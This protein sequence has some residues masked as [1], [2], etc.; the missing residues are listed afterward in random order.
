[1][2]MYT[3]RRCGNFTWDGTLR[4]LGNRYGCAGGERI[5]STMAAPSSSGLEV[6]L[7]TLQ[8]ADDTE[9][10]LNIL[11]VL[12]ELLSA[13][14][15]RRIHYMISKGGSEALLS[16]LV[17]TA[18][19][20]PPNY[21]LLLPILHL[22]AKVGH[23]DRRI[24]VKAEKAEAVLLI[25]GLL[26][27]NLKDVRRAA[28]CLWVIQVYCTSVS[29]ATLLGK[30]RGL[31]LVY[32][33]IPT[34]TT[35]HIRT[36]KAAIDALTALLRSKVNCR[37]AVSK[38]FITG[39]LKLFAD[40]HSSDPNCENLPIQ[41]AL[42]HCLHRATN[43]S[44]GRSSLVA[45]GGIALL[46]QTT[47]TCLYTRGMECLVEPTVQL[48]RKCCPKCP[49]PLASDQSVYSF[50]LPGKANSS[51]DS[52]PGI[53][54]DGFE[55]DSDSDVE[56][57]DAENRDYE[58]DLETDLEALRQ[59]P[60]PDRPLE[61][62]GQYVRLCPELHYDFQE[63]DS[64]SE[65][66]E[67]SDEDSLLNGDSDD[68]W[69]KSG[70]GSPRRKHKASSQSPLSCAL[71]NGHTSTRSR[72]EGHG[73]PEEDKHNM[74]AKDLH[75]QCLSSNE[76]GHRSMVDR[77]LEKFGS[78]IP[79]HDP[80]LYAA[81]AA[82]TR[83]IAGY[84]ILAFPDFWGH[85]PPS[86]RENMAVRRPN[87]Q[88]KKVLEDIQ[89]FLCPEDIINKVVF[90]LEDP[91][92]QCSSEHKDSLRF[93]SKFEC[94]NLRKAVHVRRYE[95][96]LILNADVNTSQY[97]QWFYFEVSGMVANVPY[98]FN[99]I[100]GE[101]TNSQFN[102][103]M[104]PVLYSVR[105]ALEGRPHWV[106]T[107]T[108]I[109]YY[110]NH[111][112]PSGQKGS[113][114]Y[115][116]TFTVTFRHDEDVCYLAYHYA[117]TYS[118]LQAHLQM[119]QRSVDP[120]KVFFRQQSL[121]NTLAGN[122]CPLV[123]IT[124]CPSSRS[125]KNL[126]Q[127]RNRP[128]VVL[129]ARVHPGESNASWVMKG[130]LEFLCS[131]DPVAQSLREAFIFKIIPMLNP[132]GVI[133][134]THRCSLT[135]EDL[136]RQWKKPDPSLSPTIYH[137]KGFLYYLNSIGRTPLVF[138]DYHGHSRKKNVF[139]Y[140]CSV[141]ETLWQSGSSVDTATLK[142]D[143]GY[144]TISKTL[145]RIAPAFSFNSCNYLVEKSRASTAR[146]VVWREIGVLRSY[147]MESTYNGCDQGIYQ[148]MQLGTRELAEMGSKFCQSLLTLRKSAMLY[149][150]KVISHMALLDDSLLD[151]KSHNCFV[152]DEPP[153][154][155]EIEYHSHV[156]L[157]PP[158]NDLDSEVNA[159]MSNTEDDDK[160][161]DGD[162]QKSLRRGNHSADLKS[163]LYPHL[164]RQ[165]SLESL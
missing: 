118:A 111:F 96:D 122:S 41:K 142:E 2:K 103:G 104:Q 121:C 90:D 64:E 51:W 38:G 158:C 56:N 69:L 157:D 141:K 75:S 21:T 154:V 156:T 23:R 55:D 101:K 50:P 53:Q 1:M 34:H 71:R 39:L 47:Q 58:D 4:E 30:N 15:D 87:L 46:F 16:A 8:D 138:C 128:C 61:Q 93:F 89:R 135:G 3:Y 19:S 78:C 116:L 110:R 123:T 120:R 60:E 32:R 153:C 76:E 9:S 106:R 72:G 26:R 48:M 42:L 94:G 125:W 105:E 36:I 99:I 62:L 13:G 40:W 33:L 68:S 150:S 129:T 145:D 164:C 134:G 165:D 148:G 86:G 59:R 12:D 5:R 143:P 52:M 63:L 124:A 114:F 84:S 67:S 112:Q 88:R 91:S 35:K 73:T 160:D 131:S 100:N 74:K 24:G 159:N 17:N 133:N 43:T 144:R 70:R 80:R 119:L 10:T 65:S 7:S 20:N 149:D 140:G 155:E 27:Q 109:C 126:H 108:E 136:N 98:R 28:A 11:N 31:D 22:L 161:K 77:L 82:N 49:L 132:D 152:D 81:A 115:T 137:T 139:L 6:L 151:H 92:P 14:T 57:E 45:G 25:L 79:H 37:T 113:C 107:G 44:L 130:S 66:E 83:S 127:L 147:T 162:K 85:L 18:N 29:T 146:V 117:Y 95:Y 102:Y 163:R 54:G 97:H